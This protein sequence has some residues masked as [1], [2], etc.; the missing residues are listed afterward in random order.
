[1]NLADIRKVYAMHELDEKE[2]MSSPYQQFQIWWEDVLKSE[3]DEPNAMILSTAD[4]KGMVESRTVL[5]KGFDEQGFVFFTNY[6]STKGRHLEENPFCSLLFFWK[7]L[8]R[9]VRI[10]GKASKISNEETKAYFISRPE[11]SRLGAWASPQSRVVPDKKWLEDQFDFFA[12]KFTDGNIECPPHWGGYR[13]A[14]EK[15]E[16]WQGRPNR[17]HDRI[18]YRKEENDNWVIERL[19]P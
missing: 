3:I 11:G 5:L 14:A 6:Q 2:V 7:E 17:M 10:T 19:A 18:Q 15:I 9:Q 16:F 1:M 12:Q 13:V 8:E 4:A